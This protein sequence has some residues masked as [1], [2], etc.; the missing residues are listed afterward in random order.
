[1]YGTKEIGKYNVDYAGLSYDGK[2]PYQMVIISIFEGDKEVAR[3]V[4]YFRDNIGI[5]RTYIVPQMKT[6]KQVEDI[7]HYPNNAR[8]SVYNQMV[9]KKE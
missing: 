3:K 7:L 2:S 5:D 8:I 9:I 6:E 1:M 4:L